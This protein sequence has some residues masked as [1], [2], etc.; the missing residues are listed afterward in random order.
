MA[1]SPLKRKNNPD[2]WHLL[3]RSRVN[4][5]TC[6]LPHCG[7]IRLRHCKFREGLIDFKVFPLFFLMPCVFLNLCDCFLYVFGD[8][9]FFFLSTQLFNWQL[10]LEPWCS[11]ANSVKKCECLVGVAWST[12]TH[13]QLAQSKFLQLKRPAHDSVEKRRWIWNKWVPKKQPCVGT[14]RIAQWELTTTIGKC[15]SG[16]ARCCLIVPGT[17]PSQMVDMWDDSAS[18]FYVF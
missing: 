8:G 15:G 14:F 17:D 10:H 6:K 18:Q 3:W 1:C 12:F 5:K 9:F 2:K 11:C 13:P 16:A 4:L 7:V